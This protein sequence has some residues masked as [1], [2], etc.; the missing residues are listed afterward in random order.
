MSLVQLMV[1]KGKIIQFILKKIKRLQK[2][3]IVM[4]LQQAI[5]KFHLKMQI[6]LK[7]KVGIFSKIIVVLKENKELKARLKESEEART[8]WQEIIKSKNDEIKAA[9]NEIEALKELLKA[10]EEKSNWF[11]TQLSIKEDAV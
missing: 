10:E 4:S 9:N 2:V 7:L 11:K 5:T 1:Q 6:Y 8:K 3:S